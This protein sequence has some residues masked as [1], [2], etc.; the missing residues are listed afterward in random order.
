MV[1]DV[2]DHTPPVPFIR[3]IDTYAPVIYSQTLLRADIDPPITKQDPHL[4]KRR[5]KSEAIPPA[6]D[7]CRTS[8]IILC[9]CKEVQHVYIHEVALAMEVYLNVKDTIMNIRTF[10][11][12]PY[13]GRHVNESVDI[14]GYR[15]W[16]V[17]YCPRRHRRHHASVP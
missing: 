7:D 3:T 1:Q 10:I 2:M 17:S 13:I 9:Q 8:W 6:L 15:L 11:L 12:Q 5:R 16:C 14:K 4:S